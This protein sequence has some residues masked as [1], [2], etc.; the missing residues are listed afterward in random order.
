MIY[1]V[2][3][4]KNRRRPLR[5]NSRVQRLAIELMVE[6]LNDWCFRPRFCIVKAM[7]HAPGAG[8]ISWWKQ[9][10]QTRKLHIQC[11]Y[12]VHGNEMFSCSET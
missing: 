9:R 6:C 12:G 10:E 5:K 7:N 2:N 3:I 8:S 11:T 1:Y 4:S